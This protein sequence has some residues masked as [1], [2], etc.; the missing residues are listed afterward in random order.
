MTQT[1]NLLTVAG[2]DLAATLQYSLSKAANSGL[3]MTSYNNSAN[4][5][6]LAVDLN[7]LAAAAV[8]V[9]ADSIAII[10]ANDSNGTRKESIADLVTA[11]AGSGLTA[12]NGVLSSDASPT[13]TGIGNAAATLV[14][15][16]NY[17]TTTFD[18]ARV[19]T[20]PS[21]AD[22]GDVVTVKAP[23]SLG[24]N[25]LTIEGYSTNTIDGD[26]RQVIASDAGAVTLTYVVSGSWKI[27]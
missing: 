17:G 25:L 27:S 5:T 8:T 24:G 16:F 11:M 22:L 4:V 9:S 26:L 2:G 12:T 15:G 1:G 13:P 10:D 23:I 7:A 14:Q 3:A 21:N 6:D 19:W 20:L 18:A